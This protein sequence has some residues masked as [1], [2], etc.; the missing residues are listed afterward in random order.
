VLWRSQRK[1]ASSSVFRFYLERQ[2]PAGVVPART[3]DG[4]LS[5]LSDR[6]GLQTLFDSLTPSELLDLVERMNVKLEEVPFQ[7]DSLDDDPAVIALPALLELLPRLPEDTGILSFTGS[8][9]L[10]RASLRILKRVPN[11]EIRTEFVRF[12]MSSVKS[13]SA[14]LILLMVAGHRDNIGIGLITPEVAAELEEQLRSDLMALLPAAFI[15]ETRTA[16]LADFIVETEDGK[17]ALSAFAEDDEV[18]LSLLVGS[19][20]NTRARAMGAAAVDVTKVLA[21]DQLVALLGVEMLTRRTAELLASLA[22]DELQLSDEQRG[23]LE[24]AADYATGRRPE[25]P[26]NRIIR[27]QGD[28]DSGPSSDDPTHTSD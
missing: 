13:L 9:V 11:D 19:T 15:C 24:L 8:M 28:V 18:M 27:I 25:L 3:V 16:R 20:G 23:A 22:E 17:S 4:A 14:R 26:F 1:I 21:W 5:L 10:M 7:V 2:L 6:D 12:A